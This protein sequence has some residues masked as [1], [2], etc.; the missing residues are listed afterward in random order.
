MKYPKSVMSL[1]ELMDM[2]FPEN[3]L[4]RLYRVKNNGLAWKAGLH[5]NNKILFDV[6]RLERIR[7]AECVPDTQ[8]QF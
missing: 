8:W 1:R 6:E 5:K 7:V 2:G 4:M 3:W